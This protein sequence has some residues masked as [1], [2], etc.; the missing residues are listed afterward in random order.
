MKS[1]VNKSKFNLFDDNV[2]I[3]EFWSF[4]NIRKYLCNTLCFDN[5]ESD[6][7]DNDDDEEG[8]VMSYIFIRNTSCF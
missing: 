3:Y 5:D 6:D 4:D 2:S 8:I 1:R 7:I